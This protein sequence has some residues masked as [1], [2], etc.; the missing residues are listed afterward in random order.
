M[1]C[2]LS[3]YNYERICPLALWHSLNWW[4][5]GFAKC[6]HIQSSVGV[7]CCNSRGQIDYEDEWDHFQ[8]EQ[9]LVK[10]DHS[11]KLKHICEKRNILNMKG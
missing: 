4:R 7:V 8:I 11:K 5:D 9:S 1:P 3:K 2:H 10:Q 6:E